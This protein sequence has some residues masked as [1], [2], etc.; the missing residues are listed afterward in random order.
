VSK[1]EEAV[2]VK[3]FTG[4]IYSK[5]ARVDKCIKRLKRLGNAIVSERIPFHCNI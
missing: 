3:L 2:P 5:N 4:I 1:L